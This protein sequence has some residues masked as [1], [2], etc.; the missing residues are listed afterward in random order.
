MNT[1]NI[2]VPG[3]GNRLFPIFLKLEN[4][5][6]LL[7]GGGYVAEEK[8]NALLSNSPSASIKV[9][10]LEFSEAV[11]SILQLR[12]IPYEQRSFTNDD[13]AGVDIVIVAVNDKAVSS[14]IY[15]AC[16][17]MKVL[18]NVA[19]QPG[20]CDFYL[21]SVVQKGN[22]KIAIS[23]NGKSPTIAKRVKELLNETLPEEMDVLLNNMQ[24]IRNSLSGTF[25]HKVKVLNEITADLAAG[26][27]TKERKS[28]KPTQ[29]LMLAAGILAGILLGYLLGKN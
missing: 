27:T 22:L 15:S 12:Q 8:L 2:T 24:K 9:I 5:Q 25:T 13:A 10:A 7:V 17:E 3:D 28:G 19:D 20:I 16:R 4:L 29:L 21:S 26:N 23:T 18:T 14:E 1:D 11:L 6:V